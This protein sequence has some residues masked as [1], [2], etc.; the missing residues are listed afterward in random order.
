M[1]LLQAIWGLDLVTQNKDY[2]NKTIQ[3]VRRKWNIVV[4]RIFYISEWQN[5]S[6]FETQGSSP[7][8]IFPI[9]FF[10]GL[11]VGIP[12]A[13]KVWPQTHYVF[14]ST[15]LTPCWFPQQGLV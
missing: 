13:G 1:Y 7:S 14:T 8:F 11:V 6:V 10:D 15:P 12:A 4:Q 9:S 2:V 3:K 5:I